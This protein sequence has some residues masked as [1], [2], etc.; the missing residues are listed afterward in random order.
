EVYQELKAK[1]RECGEPE[2]GHPWPRFRTKLETTRNQVKEKF[3]C[4]GVRFSVQV[5]DGKASLKAAPIK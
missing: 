5:K 4:R 1:K 2:D 3:G